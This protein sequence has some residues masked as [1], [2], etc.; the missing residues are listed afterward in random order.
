MTNESTF[1]PSS[2]FQLFFMIMLLL[3]EGHLMHNDRCMQMFGLYHIQN[4]W[5]DSTSGKQTSERLKVLFHP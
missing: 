3:R 2:A 4:M 5:A 1:L